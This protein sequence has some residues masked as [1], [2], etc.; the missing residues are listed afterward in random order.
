MKLFILFK[1]DMGILKLLTTD[2][3]SQNNSKGT[4]TGIP[5]HINSYLRASI[6]SVKISG[7]TKYDPKLEVSTLFYRLLY[8]TI[9]ALLT[10]MMI[11]E[12]DILFAM[13]TVWLSST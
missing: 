12:C 6:I 11:P 5:K 2:M 10:Y 8:Q 9:G 1:A 13:F 3:L 7:A 4:S